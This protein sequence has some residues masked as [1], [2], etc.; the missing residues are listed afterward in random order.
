MLSLYSRPAWPGK[1]RAFVFLLF[2]LLFPLACLARPFPASAQTVNRVVVP[3]AARIVFSHTG[4]HT[5]ADYLLFDTGALDILALQRDPVRYPHLT[6]K[7][8]SSLPTNHAAL[9]PDLAAFSSPGDPPLANPYGPIDGGSGKPGWT[10]LPGHQTGKN[11][12]KVLVPTRF[13]NWLALQPPARRRLYAQP[14]RYTL[15]VMW[16]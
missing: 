5:H 1:R 12:V 9:P 11:V 6:F 8:H 15:V 7:A 13:A 4:I 3:R 16:Q 10:L 2:S 14:K